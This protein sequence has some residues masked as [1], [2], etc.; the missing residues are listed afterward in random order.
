MYE[1]K[2][3]H[4]ILSFTCRHELYLSLT[5]IMELFVLEFGG[6]QHIILQVFNVYV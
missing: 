4:T 3:A 1:I 5:V 6:Q 2:M